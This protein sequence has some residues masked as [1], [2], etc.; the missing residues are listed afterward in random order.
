[1]EETGSLLNDGS[2]ICALLIRDMELMISFDEM[3]KGTVFREGDVVKGNTALLALA[4]PCG[5][6]CDADGNL[7]DNSEF[8]VGE[9]VEIPKKDSHSDSEISKINALLTMDFR[10]FIPVNGA[11]IGLTFRHRK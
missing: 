3:P 11:V 5:I 10:R 1:M 8:D 4:G 9:H 6:L 2:M 7:A